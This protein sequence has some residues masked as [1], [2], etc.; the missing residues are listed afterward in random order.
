M[1]FTNAEKRRIDELYGNDFQ[2]VTPDDM[3]L[4]QR[5]E[6]HKAQLHVKRDA[7]IAALNEENAARLEKV[8]QE[9]EY[10]AETL[11]MLRDK[12]VAR[13]ERGHNEQAEQA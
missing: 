1:E 11:K 10:A 3:P 8:K 6:Q 13:Y 2:G 12:A 7:E 9:A 4:V 5:W